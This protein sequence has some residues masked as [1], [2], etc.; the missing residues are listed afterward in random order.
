MEKIN[1]RY[2]NAEKIKSLRHS[3]EAVG[4][5]RNNVLIG[6][7]LPLTE[8]VLRRLSRPD[9]RLAATLDAAEAELASGE[10]AREFVPGT[11]EASGHASIGI[12]DFGGERLDGAVAD[13]RP[14]LVTSG[15]VAEAVF[16]PV[17]RTWVES[18]VD[19]HV[20]AF[21]RPEAPV[22][23]RPRR[24]GGVLS[25]DRA[26]GVRI[27]GDGRDGRRRIVGVL[28]DVFAERPIGEEV[29]YPLPEEELDR[30]HVLDQI[31]RLVD[32]LSAR[33][34]PAERL[35]GVGVEFGGHL[36]EGRVVYTSNL[37]F[38][39]HGFPFAE[40]LKAV[41]RLPVVLENDANALA[42]YK[43]LFAGPGTPDFAV[44]LL[45]RMGVGCGLVLD[46]RLYRGGGGMAGELGH[47][48][49]AGTSAREDSACRCGNPLCV[50][51]AATPTAIDLELR[52]RDYPGGY[53]AAL[54][55]PG[56]PV[57]REVLEQAGGAL[58]RAIAG[59]INLLNPRVIV[60]S[61]PPDL[62][63]APR[64]FYLSQDDPKLHEGTARWSYLHGLR[65]AIRD[66]CFSNSADECHFVV[67]KRD[68]VQGALAAA[69]CLIHHVQTTGVEIPAEAVS[70]V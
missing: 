67:E 59:L 8:R 42:L 4:V 7:L 5:T 45:T 23:A 57:V 69:A 14:L 51:R 24:A 48:P 44:V 65:A 22:A 6:V 35:L 43:N 32:E 64:D 40:R 55:E 1:V 56:H 62:I 3:D 20:A 12:R 68:A 13:G 50:E 2:V 27:I 15:K 28:T 49:V 36:H 21:L 47:L 61:G 70:R 52:A 60:L 18:L 39:W 34:G 38:N 19:D 63:G 26:I 46:G 16:L 33:L 58:G 29:T 10:A 54:R 11:G 41:L 30:S 66:G 53:E 17:D 37:R 31:V 25:N 9:D